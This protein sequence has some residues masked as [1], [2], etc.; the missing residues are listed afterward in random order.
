MTGAAT[1]LAQG[2]H[3]S[4]VLLLPA[5]I[6]LVASERSAR[7]VERRSWI[8]LRELAIVV[9][10]HLLTLAGL[11]LVL[12]PDFGFA[13]LVQNELLSSPPPSESFTT[14]LANSLLLEWGVPFAPLS[15][16]PLFALVI[17]TPG[18]QRVVLWMLP[19]LYLT[20]GTWAMRGVC[21]NGAML[22]PLTIFIGLWVA[23]SV[24]VPL[25]LAIALATLPVTWRSFDAVQNRGLVRITQEMVAETFGTKP[26]GFMVG[27]PAEAVP[28]VR[29]APKTPWLLVESFLRQHR[30]YEALC[31]AFQ[32]SATATDLYVTPNA[33]D[34]LRSASDPVVVRF[35]KDELDKH[36]QMLGDPRT[37]FQLLL[38][39]RN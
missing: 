21:A 22:A 10:A 28:V 34:Q 38:V 13:R 33:L 36:Y 27:E 11:L 39:R 29:H 7:G 5:A 15:V 19:C 14:Q 18:F 9:G 35:V 16:V 6:A 8:T 23:R 4:G 2:V 25:G 37:K 24:P 20:L 17:P 1:A 26:V 32:A 31:A 12:R 30:A 3:A